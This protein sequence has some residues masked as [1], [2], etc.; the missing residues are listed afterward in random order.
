[1]ATWDPSSEKDLYMHLP[2][3][4]LCALFS[5]FLQGQGCGIREVKKQLPNT[6]ARLRFRWQTQTFLKFTLFTPTN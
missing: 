1:M 3:A 6:V 2:V 5:K 4:F